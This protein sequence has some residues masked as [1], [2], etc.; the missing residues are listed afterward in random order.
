MT[1]GPDDDMMDMIKVVYHREEISNYQLDFLM[2]Y[3]IE[4]FT[5]MVWRRLREI[6]WETWVHLVLVNIGLRTTLGQGLSRKSIIL[7]QDNAVFCYQ[8]LTS[9][10]IM[11]KK[12][13]HDSCVHTAI[14]KLKRFP[15]P[16]SQNADTHPKTNVCGCF[17]FPF[18]C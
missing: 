8:L 11:I 3:K 17:L 12:C 7:K 1:V 18:V 9:D 10:D 15:F 6:G 14:E 13:H 2:K 4:I 16:T 5:Q